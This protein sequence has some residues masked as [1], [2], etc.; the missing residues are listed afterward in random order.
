MFPCNRQNN[1]DE[2]LS[3]FNVRVIN[4]NVAH[5]WMRPRGLGRLCF[6][7]LENWDR[8]FEYHSRR[9]G[10][11]ASFCVVLSSVV[12]GLAMYKE[13]YQMAKRVHMLTRYNYVRTDQRDG[14]IREAYSNYA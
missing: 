9:G 1:R 5:V 4:M 14:L 6:A 12:S 11:S 2:C 10:M 13:S 7:S 3:D 8:G